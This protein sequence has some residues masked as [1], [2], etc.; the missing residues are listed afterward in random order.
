MKYF[1]TLT[2]LLLLFSCSNDL[3]IYSL[4]ENIDFV[5]GAIDVND[6]THKV[7]VTK[8]VNKKIENAT[9]DEIYYKDEEV[10]VYVDEYNTNGSLKA[11]HLFLPVEETTEKG[12]IKFYQLSNTN[13]SAISSYSIRVDKT[14]DDLD[15]INQNKFKLENNIILNK[16][17]IKGRTSNVT[18]YKKTGPT[19][20]SFTWTQTGGG[21]EQCFFNTSFVETNLTTGEKDTISLNTL[22]YDDVPSKAQQSATLVFADIIRTFEKNIK[23]DKNIQREFLNV[24][25]NTTTSKIEAFSAGIEIHSFSKDVTAYQDITFNEDNLNQDNPTFTNLE[26]GI[27]IFSSKSSYKLPYT[28]KKLFFDRETMNGISCYKGFEEM[29]FPVLSFDGTNIISDFSTSKCEE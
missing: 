12:K 9:F 6:N 24:S 14:A 15:I 10:K 23:I 27:G 2:S 3:S 11:S 18:L 1:F 22:I 19:A 26:N 28:K 21:K 29:N 5:F 8:A 20:K 25:M 13:L 4:D 7:R 17:T 16:P